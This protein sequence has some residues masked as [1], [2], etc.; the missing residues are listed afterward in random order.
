VDEAELIASR[1]DSERRAKIAK[2]EAENTRLQEERTALISAV[3]NEKQWHDAAERTVAENTRQ[4]VELASARGAL[5]IAQERIAEVVAER[6]AARLSDARGVQA[7]QRLKEENTPQ[8]AR[9]A[10]VEPVLEFAREFE[11]A[12]LGDEDGGVREWMSECGAGSLMEEWH[13]ATAALSL[14]EKQSA[15]APGGDVTAADN[16]SFR[17]PVSHDPPGSCA[18]TSSGRCVNHGDDR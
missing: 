15:P 6:D 12:L 8:R 17:K 1:L 16:V 13:A 11:R 7:I 9:L 2:L 14:L 3:A 18:F 10:L 5:K 4:H